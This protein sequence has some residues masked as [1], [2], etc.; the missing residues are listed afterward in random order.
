[1]FKLLIWKAYRR[2]SP[3]SPLPNGCLELVTWNSMPSDHLCP[4]EPGPVFGIAAHGGLVK[5][6]GSSRYAR[7]W[8]AVYPQNCFTKIDYFFP[9]TISSLQFPCQ[10]KKVWR[11][12]KWCLNRLQEKKLLIQQTS[13]K[14]GKKCLQGSP[15]THQK[16]SLSDEYRIYSPLCLVVYSFTSTEYYRLLADRSVFFSP[17][18]IPRCLLQQNKIIQNM[19]LIWQARLYQGES[20]DEC[21]RMCA[22]ELGSSSISWLGS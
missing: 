22:Q 11:I 10:D 21:G 17:E 13:I 14:F 15:P 5:D 18:W 3:F 4:L 12:P 19:T 20:E 8:L 16:L 2:F 9:S 7:N 1:M 6:Q